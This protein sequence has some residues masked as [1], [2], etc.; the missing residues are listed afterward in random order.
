MLV[1]KLSWITVLLV[2]CQHGVE[3]RRRA[4]VCEGESAFLRCHWGVIK[5]IKVNYG[6]TDR[7]ICGS[8]KKNQLIS[9]T[10]CFQKTSHR[11]MSIR[12]DG[13]KSCSVPAVNSVFSDPCNGTYKYLDVSY[14]CQECRGTSVI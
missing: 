2:L 8:G 6:R 9:N 4:Q 13:T 11:I 7:T 5:I 1:Q 10:H 3:A 12:C 14:E